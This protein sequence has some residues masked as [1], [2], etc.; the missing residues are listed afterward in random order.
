M[1]TNCLIAGVG[2]QGS[3]LASRL[4]GS[5]AMA[6]G[7]DVR[8]S[9]TIGMAQRGGSVASHI[10]IGEGADSP[11][12]SPGQADAILAFEPCEAARA[13]PY[14]K[15]DGAMIVCGRAIQP[16][17]SSNYDAK[18]VIEYLEST[19]SRLLVLDGEHIK[20]RCGARALNV[21][22]L[23][24]AISRE[25]F[26]FSTEDMEKIID[27]R[28]EAAYARMNKDALRFGAQLARGARL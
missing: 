16:S 24:A 3:I 10:R 12:I 15:A 28:F 4:L 27:A 2:G 5:A 23:G 9:E 25:L 26:P 13:L 17:G 21:A 11:L 7:L 1:V 19:V 22:I 14:L 6:K 20:E 18:N 8:G